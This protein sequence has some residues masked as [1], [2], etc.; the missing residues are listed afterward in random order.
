MYEWEERKHVQENL[1]KEQDLR[2]KE[3]ERL[4]KLKKKE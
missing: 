4:I 2:R 3:K 1:E